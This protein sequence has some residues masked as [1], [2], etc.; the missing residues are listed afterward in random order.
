MADRI[1]EFI[2]NAG[3]PEVAAG[4]TSVLAGDA[5]TE[6]TNSR[7]L[8]P[9]LHEAVGLSLSAIAGM[10]VMGLAAEIKRRVRIKQAKNT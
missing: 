3:L 2:V 7:P 10:A 6:F 8:E 5:V 1:E 4:F 9:S